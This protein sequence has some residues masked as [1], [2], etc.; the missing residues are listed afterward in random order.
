MKHKK[1]GTLKSDNTRC[2]W[3]DDRLYPL[4]N[5]RWL[6]LRCEEVLLGYKDMKPEESALVSEGWDGVPQVTYII[7]LA[8][9]L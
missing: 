5:G 7:A 8:P 2:P 6:C 9:P 1:F 4:V 3:C